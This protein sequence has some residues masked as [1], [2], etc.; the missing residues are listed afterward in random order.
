VVVLAALIF[1][2]V[3]FVQKVVNKSLNQAEKKAGEHV[4]NRASQRERIHVE[5]LSTA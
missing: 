5:D 2:V 4:R 1:G 3:I